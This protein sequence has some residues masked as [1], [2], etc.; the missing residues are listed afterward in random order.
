LGDGRWWCLERDVVDGP[1]WDCRDD[2]G[3]DR[4]FGRRLPLMLPGSMD[5][6]RFSAGARG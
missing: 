6:G 5:P 2:A 1:R 3:S 4:G